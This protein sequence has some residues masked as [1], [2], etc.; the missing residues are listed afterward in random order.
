MNNNNNNI[1]V[2]HID[3]RVYINYVEYL[4]NLGDDE[5]F[6]ALEIFNNSYSSIFMSI[7]N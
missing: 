1:L 4:Q 5:R 2:V 6:Y 7:T 3:I